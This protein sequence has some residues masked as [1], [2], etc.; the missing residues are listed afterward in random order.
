M[1][2]KRKILM[3]TMGLEIGGAET[4]IVELSREL[5]RRGYEVLVAS[6][7]GVYQA[8]LEA[9]GVRCL[10]V[11]MN[12]RE[13]VAMLKSLILMWQIIRRERPDVVHAHA[14]I[15]AFLCGILHRFMHFP[16]VTT[17]HWVFDAGG[18][19]G[20]LTNWG[21]RTIA[22]SDDIK[23]Y[24]WDN[25]GIPGEQ[26]TVT[27]NGID[28]DK[29]SP[30]ISGAAVRAEQGIPADALCLA[31]VSRLDDSRAFAARCLIDIAPK[32]L[33]D[34][35][36]LH[37][38]IAGGGDV[39]DELK[40]KA[41]AVNAEAGYEALHLPGART[42]INEIVAAGDVFVG[43]SRAALEAMAGAKPVIIAGN[44]GYHGIF[45]PDKLAEAM[46]GNFCCRG[47][48][49]CTPDALYADCKALLSAGSEVWKDMGAYNRQV[50][51]D[52]YSVARMAE[53]ALSVYR[54]VWKKRSAVISGYYGYHNLGDDAILLSIRRRLESLSDDVTLTALSNAPETTRAEYGVEAVQRF[55]LFQV[56]RAVKN[57]DLLI[58]GGGSLLQDR[59]STRSLMYYLEVIRTALRYHKPVMLYANGIGPVTREKNRQRVKDVVSRVDRITLRDGDSM[60]ELKRMGVSGPEMTVTADPVFTLEGIAPAAAR[61][62]LEAAGVPLGKPILAV[63][64]RQS[65]HM[66]RNL[67]AIAAF[68][69]RAAETHTV[70]FIVMQTP[71]DAA[72][73]EDIR[74]RMTAP[75]WTFSCPGEPDT[76]MGI[77]AVCDIVFSMRLHTVIFA[78]KERVPVMG[79][80]YDPKVASYLELLGM[81]ACG[82]TEAFSADEAAAVFADLTGS[83]AEYAARLDAV[84]ARL[85]EAAGENERVL[86]RLLGLDQ[87]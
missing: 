37:I 48:P 12:R 20:K 60:E 13:P 61:Q 87:A 67:D 21:Q 44:E 30:E 22:V 1:E 73:T 14:R 27:I 31:S 82:T 62:R 24:L 42:D 6:N 72:V 23:D 17:A 49:M 56:R 43:V 54:Q 64:M 63:S 18:A 38:L 28:T 4:H 53:D 47:L 78:A 57:A 11:P 81:P 29:F 76:M 66:E 83:R 25:Y 79:L 52:N 51:F 41:D 26:V 50:I 3:A 65:G 69:D 74:T 2:R 55:N 10:S 70:L 7:G 15:P 46:L 71:D 68:C 77:I 86:A 59:T 36:G 58:S 40:A 16:F 9:A 5:Q 34:F 45:T 8:E 32:L 19:L 39:Y 85:E 75:S 84:A 35:P 80:V 33:A